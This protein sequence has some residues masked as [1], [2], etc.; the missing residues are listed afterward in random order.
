MVVARCELRSD[1]DLVETI[2]CIEGLKHADASI[3]VSA[4]KKERRPLYAH[5]FFKFVFIKGVIALEGDAF[6]F[7]A[8]TFRNL[9]HD[10]ESVGLRFRFRIHLDIDETL[11]AIPLQQILSSFFNQFG[12]QARL[13]ING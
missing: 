7:F 4:V 10:D 3:V 5:V 6:D 11:V 13:L 2:R 12:A 1:L 8:I 9:I